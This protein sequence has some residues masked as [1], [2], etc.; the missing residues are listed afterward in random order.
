MEKAM[1]FDSS[2]CIACRACQ[3]ACK[4]WWELHSTKTS[5]RGTFENPAELGPE[6]WNK[7]RFHE[8]EKM[9]Y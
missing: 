6:I 7:L 2:K 8:F 4:K 1:L 3:S 9:G 5:N